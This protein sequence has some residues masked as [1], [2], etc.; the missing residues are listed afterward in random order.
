MKILYNLT[1]SCLSK[2]R[3]MQVVFLIFWATTKSFAQ[4][5]CDALMYDTIE[6]VNFH[7]SQK[8]MTQSIEISNP[9]IKTNNCRNFI[10]NEGTIYYFTIGNSKK[11]DSPVMVR[12]KSGSDI[13]NEVTVAAGKYS[14][15]ELKAPTTGLYIIKAILTKGT[16]GCVTIKVSCKN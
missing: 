13:L 14:E 4:S 16:N 9:S 7:P 15:I 12:L 6:R 11:T 5:P 3:W 10:L 1:K 8:L 2:S